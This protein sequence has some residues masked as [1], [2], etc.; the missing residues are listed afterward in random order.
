M[1]PFGVSS[2]SNKDLSVL[3]G[4]NDKVCEIGMFDDV[5]LCLS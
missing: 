4:M 5:S 2:I 1:P 3:A